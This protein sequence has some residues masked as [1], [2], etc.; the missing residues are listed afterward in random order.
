MCTWVEIAYICIF[1][2]HPRRLLHIL[3]QDYH[4][5]SYY[6]LRDFM[7]WIFLHVFWNIFHI[8]GSL[9]IGIGKDILTNWGQGKKV[10]ATPGIFG[11]WRR[12]LQIHSCWK[13]GV[14]GGA[15]ELTE[16]S[17]LCKFCDWYLSSPISLFSHHPLMSNLNSKPPTIFLIQYHTQS[18]HA[19]LGLQTNSVTSFFPRSNV[20]PLQFWSSATLYCMRSY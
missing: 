1:Y 7:L 14:R 18:R 3:R 6:L 16:W 2:S 11:K 20:P 17:T 12:E 8:E 15:Q 19:V 9:D 13:V 10:L 4:L 5:K